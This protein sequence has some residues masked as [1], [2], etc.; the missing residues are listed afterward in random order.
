LFGIF[1]YT[2]WKLRNINHE[3]K[4]DYQHFG[5]AGLQGVNLGY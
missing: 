5:Y 2:L 3:Q 4:I 1:V